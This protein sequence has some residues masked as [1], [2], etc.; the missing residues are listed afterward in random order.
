MTTYAVA[1]SL[2][3]NAAD[4]YKD[5]AIV[6]LAQA[7]SVAMKGAAEKQLAAAFNTVPA[8][9]QQAKAIAL[10]VLMCGTFAGALDT[11]LYQALKITTSNDTPAI[12]DAEFH[13]QMK[14]I[15][16]SLSDSAAAQAGLLGKGGINVLR[17]A[18]EEQIAGASQ[19][20][21]KTDAA[22]CQ[23]FA[24][25]LLHIFQGGYVA[26]AGAAMLGGHSL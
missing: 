19:L 2:V 21:G 3:R 20:A 17:S 26:G 13:G 5:S 7:D 18:V 1:D 24:V 8:T 14:E 9:A 25:N 12:P 23:K 6:T 11:S 22:S 16:A 4:D 10:N 15:L